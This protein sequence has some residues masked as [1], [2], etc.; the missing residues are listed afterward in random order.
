MWIFYFNS[1]LFKEI[2]RCFNIR[3]NDF[4]NWSF[5]S[6]VTFYFLTWIILNYYHQTYHCFMMINWLNQN[7]LNYEDGLFDL[8]YGFLNLNS[9]RE[10]YLP[11]FLYYFIFNVLQA[12][13]A[14]LVFLRFCLDF[15]YN[16]FP[17]SFWLVLV[18]SYFILII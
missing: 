12:Q 10:S 18:S 13:Q 17:E 8:N 15:V 5:I 14:S 1:N 2:V 6:I 16:S 7:L 3:K 11:F 4:W 9:W